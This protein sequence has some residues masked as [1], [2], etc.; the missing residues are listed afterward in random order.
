MYHI[1]N[2]KRA[3]N[4]ARKIGDGLLTCLTRKAFTEITVTEIQ[5][6][7]KV[8]RAT[9]YRLFDNSSDVLAY[10]CDSVFEEARA[11]YEK[12][13]D[14]SANSTTLIFIRV[15]M[16]N[17]ALLKAIADCNRFDFIF[18][19]HMKYLY[20]AKNFIFNGAIS[21]EHSKYLMAMLTACTSATL[22]VWLTEQ[23][24]QTAEQIQEHLKQCFKTLGKIFE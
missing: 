20:P 16:K 12:T 23:G 14:W 13:L 3:K 5:K 21:E 11:E 7:A 8:G 15:W 17:K 6:T 22:S 18:N 24:E 1:S 4:S 2:D 19:S 9:F 10:L